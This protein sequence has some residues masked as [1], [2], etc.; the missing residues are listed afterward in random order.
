MNLNYKLNVN[1]CDY[2]QY[3]KNANKIPIYSEL[4]QNFVQNLKVI[5]IKTVVL[6]NIFIYKR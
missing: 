3:Y 5:R 4:F 6:Y 2:R 1:Q